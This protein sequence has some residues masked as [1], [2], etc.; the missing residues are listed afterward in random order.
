MLVEAAV[1]ET[2]GVVDFYEDNLTGQNNSVV[3]DFEGLKT[4][5]ALSYVVSSISKRAVD[6]IGLDEYFL[7][8]S[9]DF[10][11]ID[12]EGYEWSALQGARDIISRDSPALMVEIQ[13]SHNEIFEFFNALGYFLFNEGLDDLK[14]PSDLVGNTFCFHKDKHRQLISD[15]RSKSP[16]QTY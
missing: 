14:R 7:D 13:A 2:S 3:K 5:Q 4:N 11:K 8:R 10:I 9:I 15:L 12:I 1:G 16:S 6:L